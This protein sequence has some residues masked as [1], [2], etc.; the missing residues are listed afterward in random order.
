M[1]EFDIDGTYSEGPNNVLCWFMFW[2]ATFLILVVFMNMLIAIMS[3]TY[4]N[5][6]EEFEES[7]L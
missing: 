2:L 3:E 1:G 5:V 6:Q 7:G 4:A